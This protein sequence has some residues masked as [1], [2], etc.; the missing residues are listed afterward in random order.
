MGFEPERNLRLGCTN[1]LKP[2]PNPVLLLSAVGVIFTHLSYI[3]TS[4]KMEKVSVIAYG[5]AVRRPVM[6]AFRFVLVEF[7]EVSHIY[8][9]S[10]R[11]NNSIN[12]T[13]SIYSF[14]HPSMILQ[15][16]VRPWPLFQFRNIFYTDGRAPWT[17]DQ[18][19]ARPLPK[20]RIRTENNHRIK[21]CE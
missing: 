14:I 8:P 2:P 1:S 11:E 6:W 4:L 20:H 9:A 10:I 21:R 13:L 17:N 19:V 7:K 5:P 15:P 18:P 12:P 16:F 3:V